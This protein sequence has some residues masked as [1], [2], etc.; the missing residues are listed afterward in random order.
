M[1]QGEHRHFNQAGGHLCVCPGDSNRKTTKDLM[2]FYHYLL[3]MVKE[4]I[5]STPIHPY[6]NIKL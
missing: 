2:E 1:G 5:P 6:T 3:S 4:N